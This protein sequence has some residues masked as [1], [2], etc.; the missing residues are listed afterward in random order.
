MSHKRYFISAC[1]LGQKVRYDGKDCLVSKLVQALLD[2]NYVS[3]CPEVSAGL[4]TPRPAAEIRYGSGTDVLFGHAQVLSSDAQNISD[5]FIQ[6]AYKA[7]A[8]A[9]AN[10]VTHAVLKANSRSC[11]SDGIYDGSFTGQKIAGDGVT[12]ALFRQHGI[13]VVTEQQFLAELTQTKL[14]DEPN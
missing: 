6:G 3:L 13:Q 5:A 2:E 7:L 4:P 1:L 10:H 14:T 9:Q 11:G 12:A 8:L